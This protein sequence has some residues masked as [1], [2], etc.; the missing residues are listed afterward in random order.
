MPYQHE[1]LCPRHESVQKWIDPRSCVY[2]QLIHSV[3][4]DDDDY[5]YAVGIAEA[6]GR[7]RGWH[8]ALDAARDAVAGQCGHT[9]SVSNIYECDHD[10]ALAAID[11]LRQEKP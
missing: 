2:C 8:E 10:R 9:K 1:G 11:A 3:R 6:D 5:A 4:L 7:W